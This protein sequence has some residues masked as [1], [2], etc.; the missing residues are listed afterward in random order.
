MVL[1]EFE[2]KYSKYIYIYKTE[3]FKFIII[4]VCSIIVYFSWEWVLTTNIYCSI[5]STYNNFTATIIKTI[6]DIYNLNIDYNISDYR[7]SVGNKTIEIQLPYNSYHLF[8]IAGMYLFLIPAKK[9]IQIIN[10]LIFVLLFLAFR[11]TA[12]SIVKLLFIH[13]IHNVLIVWLEPS[14]N[15]A[16]FFIAY[17]ILRYSM[18]IHNLFSLVEN[19][20]NEHL[21]ISLILLIFLLLAVPSLTRVVI[22]YLFPNFLKDL[23]YLILSG[24]NVILRV[25]GYNANISGKY[26]YLNDNWVGLE[27][28]CLGLGVF[29]IVCIIVFSIKSGMMNKGIFIF[30]FFILYNLVNSFRLAMLLSHL[31][32]MLVIKKYDIQQLHSIVSL[33][34]YL[35][36]FLGIILF[37]FWFSEINLKKMKKDGK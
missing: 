37:V 34:M 31:N 18:L 19:K 21:N 24:S 20:I 23:V 3:I 28:T 14:V 12:L 30:L 10:V 6:S 32:Q 4:S 15:I 5:N 7:L 33:L 9:W 29:T 27:H 17:T 22:T 36:A 13:T 11:A 26:I 8:F 35:V 25:L 2:V 1:G 16:V